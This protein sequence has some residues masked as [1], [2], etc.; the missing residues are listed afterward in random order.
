MKSVRALLVFLAFAA[1]AHAQPALNPT[2]P[3]PPQSPAWLDGYKV[4]WPVRVLGF[5]GQQTG[6]SVLVSVPTG[7]WLKSDASDL[8]V[9]G[10]DGKLLP[11]SVLSH[12]PLGETLVQF[13]RLEN[14]SWYWIYGVHPGKPSAS[15]RPEKPFQEGLTLEVRDG[16]N[17]KI[18]SWADL[19]PDLDKAPVIGNA[20][21]GDVSQNCNPARPDNAT[22]FVASYRG[23][24]DVKKEGT[25]RF[26][27]NADDSS[28]LFVNGFKVRE[29]TGAGN[30]IG[31][32]KISELDKLSG[33]VE[34]K[35]GVHA[36][37]IHSAVGNRPASLG[38]CTVVWSP[39][40]DTKFSTIGPKDLVHPLY[41]R[42]AATEVRPGESGA[43]FVQGL[44]DFLEVQGLKVFLVR[45]QAQGVTDKLV[46]DMGDGTQRRGA[47][48]VHCFFKEED[49]V[50]KLGGGSLPA[51]QRRFRVWAES[52]EMSPLSLGLVVETLEQMEWRKLDVGRVREIFSY[53]QVCEQPNRWGLLAEVAEFLMQQPGVDLESRSQYVAARLEA[54]GQLGKGKEALKEGETELEKFAKSP[55]LKVR[56]QMAIAAVHHYQFRDQAE[57]SKI[58][59]AIL[60]EN[61]RV[62]HPNLRLAAVRWG[63]LFAEVGD[64]ARAS[65]TYRI[66]ATLGGEKLTSGGVTEAATRGALMRIAEQKLKGGEYL[67]TRQLLQ[68]LEMEYPGRRLDGLYCFLRAETDRFSGRYDEAQRHYEMI[69]K[70]PQWAGYRDRATYGIADAYLRMGQLDKAKKW[71]ALLKDEHPK[72]Y[73]TLKVAEVEKVLDSRIARAALKGKEELFE[74]FHLGFEANEKPWN[75]PLAGLPVVRAPGIDG[76]HSLCADFYPQSYLTGVIDLIFHAKNLEPGAIYL[77]EFWYRDVLRQP[78]PGLATALPYVH[79]HLAVEGVAGD[80][81][82]A[83]GGNMPRSSHHQWHKLSMKLRTPLAQ[84]FVIRMRLANIVGAYYFDRLTVRRVSDQQLDALIDFLESS[85]SP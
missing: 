61:S 37:E 15:P 7:G 50:V 14:H 52:G 41:A 43:S 36:F 78:P 3:L 4:R 45:L 31:K 22:E 17:L 33:K 9:Q 1:A 38:R 18:D 80:G 84:D 72:H 5:A 23:F 63:D 68:K 26:I 46:W 74:T 76:E 77:C 65:E 75:S 66:A 79:Y 8:A 48:L 29:K 28:F 39:P 47:S 42:T 82:L 71:F 73:E 60:D 12:D 58:Y 54:L 85:K 20:I 67:A 69:F 32:L 53:L 44:D 10:P 56:V 25:H 27:I 19:R 49:A 21:L 59:K 64:L 57:A 2:H 6:Q 34:L 35:I 55:P 30:M 81:Q 51:F 11:M 62:E 40:G 70:L 13:Q 83:V 24:L 16:K